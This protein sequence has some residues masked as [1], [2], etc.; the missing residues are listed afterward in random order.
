MNAYRYV[1]KALGPVV[2]LYV[3]GILDVIFQ[4]ENARPH[5]AHVSFECLEQAN[6]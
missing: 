1:Q 6:V 4:Q 2:I 5:I 3:Q